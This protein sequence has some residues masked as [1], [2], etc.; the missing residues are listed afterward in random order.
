MQKSLC[1]AL[2]ITAAFGSLGSGC[3]P[4]EKEPTVNGSG[5]SS[6]SGGICGKHDAAPPVLDAQPPKLDAVVSGCVQPNFAI[7][8]DNGC[9]SSTYVTATPA[10]IST[11]GLIIKDESS[12]QI[13]MVATEGGVYCIPI[14]PQVALE[15]KDSCAEP[16]C[17]DTVPPSA[18]GCVGV[19]QVSNL[20]SYCAI[21]SGITVPPRA[22][23]SVL[24][25]TDASGVVHKYVYAGCNPADL[26]M[27][28][29]E[30]IPP[31]LENAIFPGGAASRELV[32]P[33]AA[34]AAQYEVGTP[35]TITAASQYVAATWCSLEMNPILQIY[36]VIPH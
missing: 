29:S 2:F 16:S 25:W 33:S 24:V 36:C 7:T 5:G 26:K 34:F 13:Y 28:L 9:A 22:G 30:L 31:T 12:S 14:T 20:A 8:A 11:D 10:S 21:F 19:V 35:P 15:W 18:N 6:G 3:P 32:I 1:L 23:A 4:S 17:L 27:T